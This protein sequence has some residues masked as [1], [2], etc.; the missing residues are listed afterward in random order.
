MPVRVELRLIAGT[1]TNTDHGVDVELYGRD[2]QGKSVALVIEGFDPYFYL[3]APTMGMATKVRDHPEVQKDKLE[4]RKLWVEGKEQPALKVV[5]KR[6]NRVP[7][8][9][10][11]FA[12][13]DNV[14]AADIPFVFRLLYDLD[15]SACVAA[16]GEEVRGEKAKRFFVD[17]V[18]RVDA[19]ADKAFEHLESFTPPLRILS[20]DI[21]NSIRDQRLLCVCCCIKTIGAPDAT[22]EQL[23]PL[24]G[25]E[26]Q[27]L[28]GLQEQI[29]TADPDVVTGYNIDG[30]DIPHLLRRAKANGIDR[31]EW[32]RNGREVRESGRTWTVDGRAVADAWWNV[33]RI[34]HPKK[35]SLGAV[36]KQ[37][38]DATKLDVDPAQ[39]DQEWEAD[40]AKVVRYCQ[41]DAA[42]ALRLLE[43]VSALNRYMDLA[44]VAKLP[45]DDALNG[46]TS[47]LLDSI[48]IREADRKGLGVPMTR[49]AGGGKQI[50]GG[51]VHSIE[52]GLY[53]WVVVLDFASMYPSVII[54]ENLCFTTLSAT[55]GAGT[56]VSPVGVHFLDKAQREGMIPQVVARLLKDRAHAKERRAAAK[57]AAKAASSEEEQQRHW[58]E[59]R[60][61]DGLQ[62]A[63]KILTNSV[64]GVMASSFYRF[65]DQ[66]IGESITAYARQ[67][68]KRVITQLESEGVSVVYSDTDSTFCRS[69]SQDLEGAIAFGRSASAR[70]SK[71][72]ASLEFDKVLDPFFSHGMKKRY[73]ARVVWPDEDLLVR[74]YETR[75]SDSFDYQSDSLQQIFEVLLSGGPDATTKLGP[76]AQQLVATVQE[77][78]VPFE[79][80]VI[81]RSVKDEAEYVNPEGLVYV[82]IAKELKER[83]YPIVEG[84]R[85]S[86]IVTD[87]S[88]SPQKAEPYLEGVPLR[89]KPDT[90]YYAKRVAQS[91]SRVTEVFGYPEEALLTKRR[92][93][94]L[95]DFF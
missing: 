58:E 52:P 88:A 72:A 76:L 12:E 37:L 60:Y 84:M 33:R 13:G 85:V 19:T 32:G 40:R 92:Q 82:R 91:L 94:S 24:E 69:P 57:A 16:M 27:I 89:A 63:I 20:F 45:L 77:G 7:A 3:V 34:A 41:Q 9:R 28:A 36:S 71:G 78:K 46:R 15:L 83:G 47:Q 49:R 79:R 5:V 22:I 38:L 66:R 14:L 86:W 68:I 65:T 23:P 2:R 6:P 53:R 54:D 42:L 31:L 35:E 48:L 11:E 1:Y 56:H 80:L 67:N 74:G 30:Y 90:E 17:R 73:A 70:F 4:R 87:G 50:E 61:Y 95:S 55:G 25:S 18:L 59:F 8:L 43:K 75:R 29:R 39:M 64:F 81:S 21:E 10:Q 51:Y 93:V 44:A 62:D 26:R